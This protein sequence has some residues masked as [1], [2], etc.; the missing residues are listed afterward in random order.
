MK[1]LP[2]TIRKVLLVSALST[3]IFATGLA[4]A[5]TEDLATGYSDVIFLASTDYKGQHPSKPHVVYER[6]KKN[7][8]PARAE[9]KSAVPIA[10]FGGKPPYKRHT[11]KQHLEKV[12]LANF[13]KDSTATKHQHD[14][15][16]GPKGIRPPYKRNW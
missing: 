3:G 4:S 5:D 6:Q 15:Y 10:D 8:L 12:Q 13:K 1:K 2:M 14:I 7:S 11:E 9:D 16:R